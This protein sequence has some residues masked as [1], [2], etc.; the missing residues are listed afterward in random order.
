MANPAHIRSLEGS[1]FKPIIAQQSI[2]ELTRT[3]RTPDQVMD[4]AIWAVFQ[5]GYKSG[6]GA[7]ADHLKTTTDIDLMINAGFTF[8]TFD[9]SEYVIN[10]ADTFSLLEIEQKVNEL[11]WSVFNDSLT[12]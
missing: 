6:F 11:N 10:E 7:D 9:P 4:A 3:N 1:D 2:R 5:E 12:R 8:F